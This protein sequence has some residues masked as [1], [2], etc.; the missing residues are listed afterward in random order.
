MIY[1][2]KAFLLKK[3]KQIVKKNLAEKQLNKMKKRSYF[4]PCKDQA[5]V[6]SKQGYVSDM[7]YFCLET[8][9]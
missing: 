2:S 9:I 7:I 6:F 3:S 5:L 8:F 4:R 1:N